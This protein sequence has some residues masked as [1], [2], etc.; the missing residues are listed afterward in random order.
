VKNY[1]FNTDAYNCHFLEGN[2]GDDIENNTEKITV[3]LPRRTVF[4]F[5]Y[6][7]CSENYV[8]YTGINEFK[9]FYEKELQRLKS[10][11]EIVNFNGIRDVEVASD[12]SDTEALGYEV[13]LAHGKIEIILYVKGGTDKGQ[14]SIEFNP[15][16]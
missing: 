13:E 1:L 16:K 12:A 9:A 4:N 15:Q 2:T 6:D 8:T 3:P 7:G 14:I 10:N 5:K 11:G